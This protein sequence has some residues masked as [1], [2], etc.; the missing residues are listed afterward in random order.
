MRYVSVYEYVACLK[1]EQQ[2]AFFFHN[3]FEHFVLYMFSNRLTI[4]HK[5]VV[6]LYAAYGI[7]IHL[8]RL[9]SC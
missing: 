5:E 8:R 2:G 6:T 1:K 4:H 3:V 7:Y 9:R